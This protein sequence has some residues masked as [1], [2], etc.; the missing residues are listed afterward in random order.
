MVV[1]FEDLVR[2]PKYVVSGIVK[3]CEI[4]E[5]ENIVGYASSLLDP[6]YRFEKRDR[7]D[8]LTSLRLDQQIRETRQRL[9][10]ELRKNWM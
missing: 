1:K 8:A 10:Y 2:S 5:C 4:D 3:F 6:S 9:G 7:V